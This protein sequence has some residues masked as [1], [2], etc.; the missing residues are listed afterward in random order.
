MKLLVDNASVPAGGPF[1]VLLPAGEPFIFLPLVDNASVPAG[2]PF[3]FCL[4]LQ[5]TFRFRF[6]TADV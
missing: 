1:I 4:T 2:G 3:I 6:V 5:L